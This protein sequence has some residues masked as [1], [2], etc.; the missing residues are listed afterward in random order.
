MSKYL[1]LKIKS[2]RFWLVG[3]GLPIAIILA[4]VCWRAYDLIMNPPQLYVSEHESAA[5]FGFVFAVFVLFLTTLWQFCAFLY[6][7]ISSHR[8][9][10]QHTPEQWRNHVKLSWLLLIELILYPIVI[11]GIFILVEILFY[12]VP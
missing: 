11:I 2:W 6:H 4:M 12:P 1:F 3:Y 8:Q 10:K 7:L 5:D 9:K